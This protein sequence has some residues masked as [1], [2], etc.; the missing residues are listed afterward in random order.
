M[1]EV[2][3]IPSSTRTGVSDGPVAPRFH[4]LSER[5][6]TATA[7][8]VAIVLIIGLVEPIASN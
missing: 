7:F 1:L 5:L 6:R 2:Q 3:R 4:G 8:G